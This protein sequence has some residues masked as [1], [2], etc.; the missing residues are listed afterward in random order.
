LAALTAILD[1]CTLLIVQVKNDQ[2]YQA[3]ITFAIA[4]HTAVDATLVLKVKPCAAVPD[5]LPPE[6][7]TQLQAMLRGV[8]TQRLDA[9]C[10]GHR[11][12]AACKHPRRS[13]L[14]PWHNHAQ[15]RS[16]AVPH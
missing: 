6:Q 4:R 1:T 10:P 3:Q 5:R 8:A 9:E 11:Q 15:S 16:P 14:I 12:P 7:L 2:L 13:L